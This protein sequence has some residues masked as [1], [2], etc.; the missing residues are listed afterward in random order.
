MG[1]LLTFRESKFAEAQKWADPITN[2]NLHREK[3]MKNLQHSCTY[4]VG[5][6]R[7][8][9]SHGGRRNHRRHQ[10]TR[11]LHFANSTRREETRRKRPLVRGSELTIP[12]QMGET[13][14][15]SPDLDPNFAISF[16]SE[17]FA[18][19]GFGWRCG[20]PLYIYIRG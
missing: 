8:R 16:F 14:R 6:R 1:F 7:R 5:R 3:Y 10:C 15:G 19:R 17:F 12:N 13:R 4:L 18:C 20:G 2:F 11:R 9:K